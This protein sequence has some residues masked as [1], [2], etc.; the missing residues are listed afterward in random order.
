MSG[1]TPRFIGTNDSC[2]AEAER[3]LGRTFPPSFR[4]WLL[5]NNGRSIDVVDIFP[6]FD[7]RDPRKTWDSIVRNYD[8]NWQ[9]W[10]KNVAEW[11]FDS[12]MLLPIGTYANGDFC[13]LDYRQSWS[14][15][16]VAVVLW[17]HETG[18]T[19]YRARDFA[20]FL[21]KLAAGEFD[22]D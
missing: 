11:G 3:Q 12:S 1:R 13:C 19:E 22:N 5:A 7:S 6:V 14:D 2:V 18:D 9:D 8:G 4:D 10:L 21:V 20:E 16:E 17:T 15:G